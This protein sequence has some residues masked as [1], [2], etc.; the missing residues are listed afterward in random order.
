MALPNQVRALV[1]AGGRG[2]RLEGRTQERNKCLLEFAGQ[3]LLSYS[4]ER[5]L[6]LNPLEIVVVVGYLAEQVVERFGTCYKGVPVRYVFQAEQRGL[7]HAIE[8]AAERLE[9]APFMLFLADEILLGPQHAGMWKRFQEREVVA[10]L[11]VTR[12][13]DPEAVRNT[14]AL[15]EDGAGRVLRLVEKPRH[16]LSPWQGTGNILFRPEMLQYLAGTPIHPARQERELPDWIQCAI[17]DGRR[18]ESFE[19]GGQYININ[20]PEDIAAAEAVLPRRAAAGA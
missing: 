8:T 20:R 19:V 2:Q 4:L 1:L 10:L 18:V 16:A 9:G 3:P 7:V 17:D 5:S 11:G 6:A 14:Y 15:L 13:R 12:P